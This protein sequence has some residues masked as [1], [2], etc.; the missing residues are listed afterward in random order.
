MEKKLWDFLALVEQMRKKQKEFFNKG[1]DANV[2]VEA[3]ILESQV[4][5]RITMLQ[6]ERMGGNLFESEGVKA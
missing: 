3:K 4:D 5:H 2:L 1:R 6:E